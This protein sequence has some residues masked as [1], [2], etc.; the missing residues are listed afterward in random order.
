MGG[1]YYLKKKMKTVLIIHGWPCYV[2]ENH[3]LVRFFQ[4]QDYKV[5]A[6]KLFLQKYTKENIIKQLKDSLKKE[7]NVIIGI[8]LGG[9]VAQ[10][11]SKKFPKSK[12]ILIATGPYFKPKLNW[13]FRFL[14][15]SRLSDIVFLLIKILPLNLI[16]FFYSLIT[17]FMKVNYKDYKNNM[18]NNI[19]SMKNV[20]YK[21]Y[22]EI[23][24]FALNTNTENQLKNIKN[25]TLIITGKNDIAMPFE[26]SELLKQKI[27]KSELYVN[28]KSH[29][30][31]INSETIKK[32]KK[33][34]F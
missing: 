5:L 4:E 8:S 11:F 20:S 27:P 21:I 33:F 30:N 16:I 24:Q 9:I 3:P 18:I 17:P 29:H 12:L 34:V 13:F 7:P 23:F 2:E 32:V 22:R 19:H 25:K 28:N 15:K 26:L 10:I 6:P 31:L 14:Y 1:I